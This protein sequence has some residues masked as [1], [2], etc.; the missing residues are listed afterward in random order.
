MSLTVSPDAPTALDRRTWSTLLVLCGAVFL[1]SLD[2]SMVSVALPSI[3][4]DLHLSTSTLQ[5]VVSAYVLG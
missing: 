3:R 5:W 2:V 4:T 1:D